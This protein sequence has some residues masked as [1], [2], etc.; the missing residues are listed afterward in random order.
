MLP[1]HN[2]M[3]LMEV[4]DDLEASPRPYTTFNSALVIVE[5]ETVEVEV[6]R[7]GPSEVTRWRTPVGQIRKTR[8]FGE[9]GFA[10]YTEEYPLKTMKD[11]DVMEYI[12]R[13]RSVRF[14]YETYDLGKRAI[15][16]RA[17]P[18]MY[19]PR[20]PLQRLF[21]DYMGFENTIYALHDHRD[22]MEAFMRVI[23]ETDDEMYRAVRMSPI[24]LINFGD[25]VHSDMANQKLFEKYEL[26]YY[27]RR[28]A[29]LKSAGKHT[30]AHWDGY[31]K[32]LLQYIRH[33]GL[34]GIEAITP[35]PQ[36]D[37]N[38]DE[39]KAALG[40]MVLLDGIP[41]VFFL[42]QVGIKELEDFVRRVLSV[43]SPRVVL[44]IS[45]EMPPGGDIEKVR[46]VSQVVNSF[47]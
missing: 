18:C 7:N 36:G 32:P 40:D 4:Y 26:P 23:E 19:L 34:D 41:A 2:Q 38:L 14:D 11:L 20:I 1:R 29:E 43:F 10:P 21:I 33:T 22:R 30:H 28:S 31:V 37:V 46:Q 13:H 24:Q 44:G 35:V 9:E 5:H 42:T 25:N 6:D 3:D 12:L 47:S 8:L 16:D 45:D 27:Q 15:G 17:E 39:V